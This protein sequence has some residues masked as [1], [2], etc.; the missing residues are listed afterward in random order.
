MD[1]PLPPSFPPNRQLGVLRV[2]LGALV[3]ALRPP[4]EQA[5]AALSDL[6][7][8]LAALTHN[9]FIGAVHSA[10]R[11]LTQV[12]VGRWENRMQKS[13]LLGIVPARLK[14]VAES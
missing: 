13:K 8:R 5:L 4:P 6:L 7:P 10:T 2:E 1:A 14:G 3:A 9:A 12:G 11:R